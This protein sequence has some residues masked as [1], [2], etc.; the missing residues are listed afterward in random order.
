VIYLLILPAAKAVGSISLQPL[1]N[2][3]DAP[4]KSNVLSRINMEG[5]FDFQMKASS[6]KSCM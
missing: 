2:F 3:S 1:G 5:V 6:K 4:R